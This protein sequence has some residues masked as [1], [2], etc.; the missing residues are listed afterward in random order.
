MMRDEIGAVKLHLLRS[1]A[2][3]QRAAARIVE[4]AADQAE[5]SE[6]L[7]DRLK[8]HIRL[9]E[10]YERILAGQMSLLL[11]RSVRRGSPGKPWIN[12]EKNVLVCRK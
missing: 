11:P 12:S 2:R 1:L 10:D 6:E 3:S 5:K 7:A 4:C 9:I 8:R